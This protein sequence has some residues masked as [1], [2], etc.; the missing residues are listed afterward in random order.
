MYSW[1]EDGWTWT[2]RA[3]KDYFDSCELMFLNIDLKSCIKRQATP[4]LHSLVWVNRIDVTNTL[5]MFCCTFFCRNRGA[6][7][8]SIFYLNNTGHNIARKSLW[9]LKIAEIKSHHER[10]TISNYAHSR[11]GPYVSGRMIFLLICAIKESY[12]SQSQKSCKN[13]D[14]YESAYLGTCTWVFGLFPQAK[15]LLWI[16]YVEIIEERIV[17]YTWRGHFYIL[18]GSNIAPS[19]IAILKI[20]LWAKRS[21]KGSL[22]QN[23]KR[24]F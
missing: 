2:I 18:E 23:K 13:D 8:A 21:R 9:S 14:K 7:Y 5:E 17:I 4:V 15:K 22:F 11:R 10:L 12:Q 19:N 6:Y 24:L 16:E 3:H 20:N 1:F